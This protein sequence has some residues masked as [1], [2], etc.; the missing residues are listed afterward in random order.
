MDGQDG[1]MI[2]Q[3]EAHL[4]PVGLTSDALTGRFLQ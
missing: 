3:N 1:W 4:D 2:R